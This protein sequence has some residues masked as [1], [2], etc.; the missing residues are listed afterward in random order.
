MEF[1]NDLSL[2]RPRMHGPAVVRLQELLDG[3]GFDGGPND[4][5]FGPA[6]ER[7]VRAFQKHRGL[8]VD[9][10]CGHK[11]WHEVIWF[12]SVAPDLI[13]PGQIV[14]RR[15]RHPAPKL[16]HA[17]RLEETVIGVMLHQTGCLMPTSVSGWDRLNAHLGIGRNGG[18]YI[19]ND[20][21]DLI[22]HGQGLSRQTVGLEIAGNYPGLRGNEKTLWKGGGGPHTLNPEM[23]LGLETARKWL[24]EWFGSRNLR[25]NWIVGHRQ[26]FKTRIADPGQEIWE[27]VALPWMAETGAYE[28]GEDFSKGSG[29]PIPREWA[30]DKRNARYWSNPS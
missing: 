27:T 21:T 26:S 23:L 8:R 6:T 10:V 19:V 15:G 24:L 18:F 4:G 22:F 14:D 25:W 2:T 29:R 7:M 9:G 28:G 16:F 17:K 13:Q 11:T 12:N 20:P 5:V 1:T 3:H 30:G